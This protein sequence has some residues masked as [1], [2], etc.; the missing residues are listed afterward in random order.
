VG[1][2]VQ[3]VVRAGAS[4]R[5]PV[6]VRPAVRLRCGHGFNLSLYPLRD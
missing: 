2:Y 6:P 1:V 3:E 4:R 5:P